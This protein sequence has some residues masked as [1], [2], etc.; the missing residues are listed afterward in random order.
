MLDQFYKNIVRRSFILSVKLLLAAAL[1]FHS[2][3]ADAEESQPSSAPTAETTPCKGLKPYNNIDELLY[4]FYI[5]LESD[6]LFE[7]SVAELEEAW[8]IKILD[9]ERARPKNFY[10]LSE[11]E[12]L[13]KPYKAEKDA[14]YIERTTFDPHYIETGA[15]HPI[16]KFRLKPTNEY[17]EKH[18]PIFPGEELPKLL[19]SSNGSTN[20]LYKY[21]YMNSDGARVIQITTKGEVEVWRRSRPPIAMRNALKPGQSKNDYPDTTYVDSQ[22]APCRGLKRY[23]DLDELL[24]Q[25]YINLDSDCLFKMP[26]EDLEKIWDTKILD[27]RNRNEIPYE[28]SYLYKSVDFAGKPYTSER[29]AFYLEIVANRDNKSA[30]KIHITR[31]YDDMYRTLLPIGR[32]SKFLPWPIIE[33]YDHYNDSTPWWRERTGKP[34]TS[35]VL[36]YWY[37]SDKKHAISFTWSHGLTMIKIR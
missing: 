37:S 19:P 26:V 2:V 15:M 23:K 20:E 29:D 14:F 7:M 12:F 32:L 31:E 8:G 5:N 3:P 25:F 27:E 1:L 36:F 13:N 6:C 17:Y 18:G 10:P 21:F 4:Q 30:F 22:E 35:S 9:D 34:G 11:T 24:Y 28:I 33:S 16:N